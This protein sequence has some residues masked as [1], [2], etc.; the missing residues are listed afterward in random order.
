MAN[1]W[2]G[3]HLLSRGADDEL[4]A[5]SSAP[6]TRGQLRTAVTDL[7]EH[8]RKQ[9]ITEGSSVLLRMKPSFT[10]LQVLLA[11]WS[12]GAQV[13]LV[14]FRL[15]PA[16]YEPLVDLV[17]PQYLVVATGADGP[18][19]G[20]RQ[21]SGFSVQRLPSGRPAADGI[22]LVQFSSGST[23]RPKVIGRPADSV[24]AEL[25]RHSAL[26]GIPGRGERVVLL[27]SVMH[28]MGLVS[29]VLHALAAGA[30]LIV[31]P[32]LRPAEVVRL[33][34]RA[35]ASAVYGTPVH[36][37]LLARIGGRPELPALRLAVSGGE[38]VPQD[39]YERFRAHFGLPISPVYGVTEIGLIAG[40][41]SGTSVPP[42]LGPPVPGAEVKV[43]GEE[44]FVRMEHSPYLY[45]EHTDRFADG[46]LRTYDR[47]HQDP[48]TGV[49][50]ML[51]RADSLVVVG[52]LKVDLTEV[53]T[54][55]LG[56]PR[57]TEAVV[58]HEEVIEAF[59]GA[60]QALTADELVAWCRE[61][62]SPVK[63]PKRFF[64]TRQLPR[65]SMGKL[66]RDRALMHGR[67]TSE[68]SS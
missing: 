19:V 18:V 22:R 55:L 28:N 10:Y 39:T 23:G 26:P 21:E 45:S 3:S 42:Q 44:L 38:R 36:Y 9:G 41:L 33:M 49:L 65:N 57:V 34:A 63:N 62:L 24:L 20:F 13:V 30:T 17:R 15:K 8:F 50:S 56:H 46:W 31:P 67:I 64:V 35:E 6:V 51:G 1:T 59:V 43:L 58:T 47:V 5:I 4:W 7:G 2:W 54:V 32:T 48:A 52:G 40:D 61:R 14:D 53:E 68:S 37:D 66:V 16:E 12:R 60:D 27:N 11:L 25:D 29:G